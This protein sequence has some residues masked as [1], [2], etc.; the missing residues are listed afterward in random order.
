M[1]KAGVSSARKTFLIAS[2]LYSLLRRL[3]HSLTLAI[4]IIIILFINPA[5]KL[6]ESTKIRRERSFVF[7]LHA[8]FTI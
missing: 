2:D 6:P 3:Y 1:K 7:C 4:I 8:A 5:H